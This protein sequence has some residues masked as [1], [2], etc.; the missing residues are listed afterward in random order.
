MIT[1]QMPPSTCLPFGGGYKFISMEMSIFA[2][3]LLQLKILVDKPSNEGSRSREPWMVKVNTSCIQEAIVL[4]AVCVSDAEKNNLA[5]SDAKDFCSNLM[6]KFLTVGMT[7]SFI[8]HL[9]ERWKSGQQ[10]YM[11]MKLLQC[12]WNK[13]QKVYCRHLLRMEYF[14]CAKFICG[15]IL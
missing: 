1:K 12:I 6:S 5:N 3:T 13:I 15:N 4:C 7:P 2:E 14:C 10:G 11:C 8:F 9:C